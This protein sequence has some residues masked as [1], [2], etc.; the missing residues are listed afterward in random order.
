MLHDT[1]D[2]SNCLFQSLIVYLLGSCT[3]KYNLFQQV[4]NVFFFCFFFISFNGVPVIR[5]AELCQ[6]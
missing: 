2:V 6:S 1:W 4:C 5:V 3:D